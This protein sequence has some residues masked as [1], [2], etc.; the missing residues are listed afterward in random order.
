MLAQ[1]VLSC[2]FV[3]GIADDGWMGGGVVMMSTR[4]RFVV[5]TIL[6]ICNDIISIKL[7]QNVG[8]FIHSEHLEH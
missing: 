5:I 8:H 7:H 1:G 2:L 6:V 4:S 3:H